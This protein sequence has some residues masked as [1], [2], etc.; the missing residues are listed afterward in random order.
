MNTYI[1]SCNVPLKNEKNR[2]DLSILPV[3]L[4][5]KMADGLPEKI[6]EDSGNLV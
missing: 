2:L 1:A 4:E 3:P 6:L 5:P